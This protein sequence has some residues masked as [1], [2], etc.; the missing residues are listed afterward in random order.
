MRETTLAGGQVNTA[1]RPVVATAIRV[2]G[3]LVA[4]KACSAKYATLV[5]W[6]DVW[7]VPGAILQL[8]SW[9]PCAHR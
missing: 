4:P 1:R 2:S 9:Y 8:P 6:L 7:L 3:P 5:A